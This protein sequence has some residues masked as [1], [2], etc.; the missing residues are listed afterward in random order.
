MSLGSYS[1]EKKEKKA[2]L[3]RCSDQ[4]YKITTANGELWSKD[5]LTGGVL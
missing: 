3:G 5:C 2:R 1:S 4:M